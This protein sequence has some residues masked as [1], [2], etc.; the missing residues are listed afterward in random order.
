MPEQSTTTGL[1][2][3]GECIGRLSEIWRYPVKSMAG[4]PL[5]R[6]V[7]RPGSGIDGDRGYAVRDLRT[8]KILTAKAVAA[9]LTAQARTMPTG[10]VVIELPD[11]TEHAAGS[12][13]CDTALSQWL[14]RPV[15]LQARTAGSVWQFDRAVEPS[16]HSAI[17]SM[18][19]Q[20][21]FFFDTKSPIHLLTPQSVASCRRWV[22]DADWCV[23][24]FRANLLVDAPGSSFPED[25][26][27]GATL[28]LGESQ[29]WVR[30]EATRCVVPARAHLELPADPRIFHA[31]ARQRGNVL[32]IRLNPI[33]SGLVHRG[34]QVTLQDFAGPPPEFAHLRR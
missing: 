6:V 8:G 33:R 10:E 25:D 7:V 1:A 12:T 27:I 31:I 24:R 23:R 29:L 11:G 2:R 28:R 15:R 22:P 20:P 32:G 13:N 18:A 21:G 5:E 26:W 19:T 4:E 16:A 9:L 34:Q 30:R 3:I 17:E 14:D